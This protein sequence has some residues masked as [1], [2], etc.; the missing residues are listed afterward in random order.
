MDPH[1]I[2][3][4]DDEVFNLNALKRTLRR[5]YN[6]F[7]ATNGE[8][9]LSIMDQNDIALIIS[10]HRMPGMTGVELLKKTSKK[11]PDTV[12]IILTAYTDEI[13]LLN[14]INLGHVYGYINKPWEPEEIKAV[15]KEGIEFYK[16]KSSSMQP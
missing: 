16:T 4:V 11:H 12:R 2:L 14:A 13:L 15:V 7:S 1:N 6:V 8:E 3:V 10:D 9:A 5:E